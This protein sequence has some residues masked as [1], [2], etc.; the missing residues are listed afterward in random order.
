MTNLIAL[1]FFATFA[2]FNWDLNY[3]ILN[4][5]KFPANHWSKFGNSMNEVYSYKRSI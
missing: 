4:I 3:G 1:S 5:I 2:I